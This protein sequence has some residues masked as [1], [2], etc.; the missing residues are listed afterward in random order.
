[1][2]R[3][4]TVM[5]ATFAMSTL[6]GCGSSD[7]GGVADAGHGGA[8]GSGGVQG[9]GGAL[10]TGGGKGTGGNGG[11]GGKT[12]TGGQSS[13][14]ATGTSTQADL[15]PYTVAA[16][17]CE[18]AC[19]KLH[20]FTARCENDPTVPSE[21]QGMLGIYGKVEVVC[22]SSCAVVAP[23]SQAQWSCFQGMPDDAPCSA[24]GGCNAT[25]CP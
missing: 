5:L 3:T 8:I 23:A 16:F 12:G 21:I 6:A 13:G 1:M 20:D 17:A 24:I 19:K 2:K 25:S 4:L 15:C 7:S 9:T 10:G 14:G 11:S 18:A 22:T